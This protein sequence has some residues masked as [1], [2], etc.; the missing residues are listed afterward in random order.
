MAKRIGRKWKNGCTCKMRRGKSTLGAPLRARWTPDHICPLVQWGKAAVFMPSFPCLS[1][2]PPACGTYG[3][4]SETIFFLISRA[5]SRTDLLS[6]HPC[7]SSIPTRHPHE[8]TH[9]TT[10]SCL[11]PGQRIPLRT[12][13]SSSTGLC[14]RSKSLSSLGHEACVWSH[15]SHTSMSVAMAFLPAQLPWHECGAFRGHFIPPPPARIS[16]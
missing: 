3:T 4:N 10:E 16:L 1:L 7:S 15:G 13:T 2:L 8:L 9:G 12:P 14:K 11:K 6:L 5:F